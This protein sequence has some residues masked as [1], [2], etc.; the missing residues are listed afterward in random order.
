MLGLKFWIIVSVVLLG[1]FAVTA[2]VTLPGV[3]E[4]SPESAAVEK[5]QDASSDS[6]GLAADNTAPAAPIGT[7][8]ETTV[9]AQPE[10]NPEAVVVEPDLPS[11]ETPPGGQAAPDFVGID[12][13]MNSAPLTMEELRGKVVLVDFWTYT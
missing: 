1:V 2:L 12:N 3:F 9:Q 10:A 8:L 5:S 4:P 13:W 6:L 11:I 7:T